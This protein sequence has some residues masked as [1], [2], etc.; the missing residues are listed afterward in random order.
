VWQH[1]KVSTGKNQNRDDYKIVQ[2]DDWTD[3]GLPSSKN[4]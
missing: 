1:Q 4:E 3:A 2:S